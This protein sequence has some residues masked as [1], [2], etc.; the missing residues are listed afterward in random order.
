MLRYLYGYTGEGLTQ[1]LVT[2]K[3]TRKTA[4]EIITYIESAL[5]VSVKASSVM[6]AASFGPASA[7]DISPASAS[8]VPTQ[9]ITA[10]MDVTT[11]T[12]GTPLNLK[13]K[14]EILDREEDR[15]ARGI[16]LIVHYD[17]DYV[18][19]Q[20]IGST[21]FP[22]PVGPLYHNS[23]QNTITIGWNDQ[24]NNWPNTDAIVELLSLNFLVK[25]D[26]P[27]GEAVF[28]IDVRYPTT[29]YN[30]IPEDGVIFVTVTIE[31]VKIPITP[32]EDFRSVEDGITDYS[33][34]LAWEPVDGATGYEIQYR[35]DG[36][37]EEDWTTENVIYVYDGLAVVYGLDAETPYRFQI[38]SLKGDETSEWTP[39]DGIIVTTLPPPQE[40]IIVDTLDDL[41]LRE[42]IA[43]ADSENNVITFAKEIYGGT[44]ILTGGELYI[45]K[46]I[47][48]DGAGADITIDAN[49]LSRVFNI[50]F[51]TT[52]TLVGLT[53][54]GGLTTGNG[55]GI[56]NA[57]MLTLIDCTITGNEAKRGGGVAST[58]TTIIVNSTISGNTSHSYGGGV[59]V[60]SGTTTIEDCII[61][62]NKMEPIKIPGGAVSGG[63]GGGVYNA[64]TL[65]VTGSEITDNAAPLFSGGGLSNEGK[66]TIENCL[67]ARNSA[68][69]AGGV[70]NSNHG[71]IKIINCTIED[72]TARQGY[73]GVGNAGDLTLTDTLVTENT[74]GKYG[75]GL[76][77]NMGKAVL[78]GSTEI[79]NNTPD[80][81]W[82]KP[83]DAVIYHNTLVAPASFG[84]VPVA[85]VYEI[86]TPTEGEL[87]AKTLTYW[88]FSA[89]AISSS[90]IKDWEVNW[91]DGSEPTLVLGGPRSRIN[92][93][94]YFREAGTYSV[95]IK[96]TD[97]DGVVNT[98]TIGTYT[99]KERVV[100]PLSVTA[101][102]GPELGVQE[103]SFEAPVVSAAAP[104]QFTS[105]SRFTEDYLSDLMEIMRQRQMLDLD[106]SG[107][108]SEGVSFTE[109]IWE[110]D[111]L[112]D[113]EWIGFAEQQEDSDFWDGIFENDLVLLK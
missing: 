93:T 19:Y 51:G 16:N 54:I 75:G 62:G 15:L 71:K 58:G 79:I 61:T 24:S 65:F 77:N 107:Q 33:V 34:I 83:E 106:L 13:V 87:F 25:E 60:Q 29:G 97:F 41:S 99:V 105:E 7:M 91:G 49:G 47:I 1:Y 104:M 8:E 18:V 36:G 14:H 28:E 22:L 113:A 101:S 38:R 92:V 32:P 66:A 100:E 81:I 78:N 52:V 9:R 30:L 4:T 76:G 112:F 23:E 94:H 17:P 95:T 102:I 109:L 69:W 68:E 20:P 40:G 103:F 70:S 73:G 2:S 85:P 37:S 98:I 39:E 88:E 111:E 55:G 21:N 56:L 35:L 59:Y 26:A 12:P 86:S 48:I 63:S 43:L 96:T 50:A 110:D 108:K 90:A 89:A 44:I 82:S 10:K 46:D 72:N 84:A 42:A 5:P 31:D 6:A 64:G 53:L 27:K 67:I 11:A 45:D 74:V 57:G 80:D 3:S